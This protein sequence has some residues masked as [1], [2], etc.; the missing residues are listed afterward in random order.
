VN[1]SGQA[2]LRH[3]PSGT[4]LCFSASVRGCVRVGSCDED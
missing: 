4:A 1:G 3:V 2:V